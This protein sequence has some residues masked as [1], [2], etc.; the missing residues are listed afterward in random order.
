MNLVDVACTIDQD[1][2]GVLLMNRHCYIHTLVDSEPIVKRSVDIKQD[3]LE[4]LFGWKL[5]IVDE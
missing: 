3:I 5:L 2:Y 4:G 1:L